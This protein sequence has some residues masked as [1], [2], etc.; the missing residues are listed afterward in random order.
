MLFCQNTYL[1]TI[2]EIHTLTLGYVEYYNELAST[3]V[4]IYALISDY[5]FNLLH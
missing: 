3:I 5:K 1:S 4:E 2:V